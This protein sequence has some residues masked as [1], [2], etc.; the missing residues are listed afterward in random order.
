MGLLVGALTVGGL[1][2]CTGGGV[3]YGSLQ[4]AIEIATAADGGALVSEVLN[5]LPSSNGP[6]TVDT[7]EVITEASRISFN[8]LTFGA[9]GISLVSIIS[10]ELLFQYT[11]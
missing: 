11:L 7:V 3:A 1:L 4:S 8:A 5:S 9:M 2:L 10:K 6:A